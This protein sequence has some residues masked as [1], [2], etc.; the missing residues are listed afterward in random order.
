MMYNTQNYW[1]F[2]LC[3]RGDFQITRKGVRK[4]DLYA[5]LRIF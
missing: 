5:K 2:G 4:R 3:H 1:V